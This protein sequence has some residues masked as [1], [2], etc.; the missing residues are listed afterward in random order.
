MDRVDSEPCPI[1]AF[2]ISGVRPLGSATTEQIVLKE[3]WL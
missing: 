1:A 3:N 2:G